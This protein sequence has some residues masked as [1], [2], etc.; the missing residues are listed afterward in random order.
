MQHPQIA[1]LSFLYFLHRSSLKYFLIIKYENAIILSIVCK[2]GD[3]LVRLGFSLRM[4]E[5]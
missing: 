2:R 1:I 3:E 4:W 5:I